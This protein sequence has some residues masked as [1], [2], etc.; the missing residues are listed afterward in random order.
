MAAQTPVLNAVINTRARQ[1][2]R[3]CRKSESDNSLPSFEIRH[4]DRKHEIT[5]GEHAKLD[6]LG[7]FVSNCG[8]EFNARQHR[9]LG[10]DTFAQLMPKVVRD[11]LILDSVAIETE[12]RNDKQMGLAGFYA[13]DGAT[14]RLCP[15]TGY[16]NDPDLFAVQVVGGLVRTV[17]GHDDLIYEPRNPRSDVLSCG[18]GM[19]ET[20]LL[21]RVVTGFLNAMALNNNIFDK[22]SIL[23]GVLHMSGQ[24]QPQDIEAFKMYWQSMV[25]G[26]DNAF[27][28]PFLWSPNQDSKV[29]FEKF[30]VDFN[31]IMFAT[32]KPGQSV[33]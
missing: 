14:I 11:S 27:A 5:G 20:E 15:E 26:V 3:F 4:I 24:Y 29:S 8:F 6:L 9:K 31:E 10:R 12:R 21:V 7:R 17:Y 23:K 18:Y 16:N 2:S 19:P 33:F 28:I 32:R 25:H 22:N 13:V 1:V 30:G